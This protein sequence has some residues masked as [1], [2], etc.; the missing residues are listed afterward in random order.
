MSLYCVHCGRMVIQSNNPDHYMCC[1]QCDVTKLT[2][3]EIKKIEDS[4]ER[5][6][7]LSVIATEERQKGGK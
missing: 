4:A 7:K 1:P 5:F 3:E 2:P 6:H